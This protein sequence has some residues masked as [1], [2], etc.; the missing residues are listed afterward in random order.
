[1]R[2]LNPVT[3]NYFS[4]PVLLALIFVVSAAQANDETLYNVFSLSSE[5]SAEVDND[6]MVATLVVAAEDKDPALLASKINASMSWA[7]NVLRPFGALKIKTRDYQT[8]PRYDSG[9]IR[10]L[11]GWR[12][13]QSIQVETDDFEAAGKAI[14]KLQE[15]LQVQSIQL[16]AKAE[17][18]TAAAD[19]LIN[20]ALS[21]FKKR[22]SL[23]QRNMGATGF[24]ILDVNIQSDQGSAAMYD[25]RSNGME[26]MR[27]SAVAEPAIE[28]GTSRVSVQVYGRVQ[29]D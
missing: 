18:R 21:A 23:I 29:L 8:Y 4:I 3:R 2:Q 14:Q 13:S 15:R 6:L 26:M 27:S 9:K 20:D 28:A 12:G 1:M 17:T 24:R 10:K 16:A 5:A 22:A 7:V 11:I 19:A 25:S